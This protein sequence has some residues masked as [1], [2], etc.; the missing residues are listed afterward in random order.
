MTASDA[1][2]LRLLDA[3]MLE[4][5]E[6]AKGESGYVANRFLQMLRRRGGLDCA[7]HLMQQPGVSPGFLRLKECGRL[8]LSVEA[9]V[10]LRPEFRSL[11]SQGEIA[12]AR[13]RLAE[14]GFAG[15]FKEAEAADTPESRL[16][17][18][19]L[20]LPPAPKPVGHYVP[21]VR[22]GNLVF[23]SGQLPTKD[24]EL[25]TQGHVGGEVT[26][27]VAQA[28]VRQAALNALAVVAA[29]AGGLS[30]VRRVV[31]LTGHVASAPGFRD[32]ALVMNAASEL[33]VLAFGDLGR[34]SRAALGAAEL[35]LGAPV[36]LEMIVEVAPSGR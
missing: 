36:E 17:A 10:V 25:M 29:E 16:A 20:A 13:R 23:V 22:T 27:E 28:C 6:K 18:A 35:P 15:E 12:V 7:H 5:Y 24:G 4:V 3:A 14:H 19:G 32:Q 1:E 2:L 31:R 34:H 11:F 26:L 33:M 8:D 9:Y 21:A 30:N